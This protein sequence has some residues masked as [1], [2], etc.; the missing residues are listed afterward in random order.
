MNTG[1]ACKNLTDG[2]LIAVAI[3]ALISLVVRFVG[4]EG[5]YVMKD[6]SN[7]EQTV[8][9]SPLDD[10]YVVTY[11]KLFAAFAMAAIIGFSSRGS[12]WVGVVASVCATVISVNY[13]ADGIIHKFGFLYI[14]IAVTS[15]GGN[16]VHAYYHF[17]E[18][19]KD[20]Q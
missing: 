14:L 8:V 4:F 3:L 9:S 16:L 7:G 20:T 6:P 17:A 12:A 5:E 19:E 18:K 13:F 10:P 11:I 15:I 2:L 1:R